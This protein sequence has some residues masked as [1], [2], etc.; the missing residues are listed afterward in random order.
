MYK[1]ASII[2]T[3]RHGE[4]DELG[5]LTQAGVQQSALR[6]KKVS[7]LK[8]STLLFTSG[9]KRVTETVAN[10][11]DAFTTQGEFNANNVF[12]SHYLH[13]LYDPTKKGE[14][15]SNWDSA[16][17]DPAERI[18][19][20]LNQNMESTEPEI[21]PS[22][23]QM[24]VRLA[25]VLITQIDF[26]TITVPDVMSNF[27]NGTHEP[28][29]TSFLFYF[30][31]NFQAGSGNFINEIGGTIDYAEG[32]EILIYQALNKP[33]KLSFQFRD[34]EIALDQN[35]LREFAGREV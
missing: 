28:V 34:R 18:Q 7:Y 32:F 30:L 29:I 8:G 26:A 20:F 25:R 9:V 14:L 4:K 13:Y 17:H 6:G 33:T 21:Y 12:E 2:T 10:L 27:V 31:N 23:H 11:T 15:F 5:E 16:D 19:D 24:A 35:K 1:L 3:V 22:P